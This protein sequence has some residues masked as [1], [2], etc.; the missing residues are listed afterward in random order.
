MLDTAELMKDKDVILRK[1]EKIT[2]RCLKAFREDFYCYDIDTY[3]K[4][5]EGEVFFWIARE[6]GTNIAFLPKETDGKNIKAIW[7]ISTGIVEYYGQYE[8]THHYHIYR[9]VKGKCIKQ[10]TFSKALEEINTVYKTL[11]NVDNT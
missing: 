8:E 6:C 3:T 10:T 7:S 9:I 5:A 1:M 4:A 2:L 11:C